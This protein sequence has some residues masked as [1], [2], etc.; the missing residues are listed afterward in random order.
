MEE[1]ITLLTP[2][3]SAPMILVERPVLLAPPMA[4]IPSSRFLPWR[5]RTILAPPFAIT[6]V[7]HLVS[8]EPLTLL[9]GTP[10]AVETALEPISTLT[11]LSR[12][13]EVSMHTALNP[14]PATRSRRNVSS[15]ALVSKDPI[16]KIR[17]AMNSLRY[18][19]HFAAG[20]LRADP[21]HRPLAGHRV[22][23]HLNRLR[24]IMSRVSS[25]AA[26]TA[27][28]VTAHPDARV[29]RHPESRPSAT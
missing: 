15:S 9:I 16:I 6:S 22:L 21:D 27:P 23:N 18:R 11:A 3:G 13:R 4:T 7:A 28:G 5:S 8:D 1:T 12:P 2:K 20:L 19:C 29:A 26:V 25:R 10:A 17:L 24:H 14:S